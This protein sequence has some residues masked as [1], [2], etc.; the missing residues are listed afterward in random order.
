[1]RD[2]NGLSKFPA[3]S[4]NAVEPRCITTKIH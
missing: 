2:Q 1:M 3:F 4:Q